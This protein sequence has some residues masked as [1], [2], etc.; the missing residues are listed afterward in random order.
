[1]LLCFGKTKKIA[2][3]QYP[4]KQIPSRD[5]IRWF[6]CNLN[7]LKSLFSEKHMLLCFGKTKKIATWQYPEKRT[8]ISKAAL[9][10]Y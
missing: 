4:E 10:S 2:T 1:M 6:K 3:W 7:Q 5:A 8:K 9:F